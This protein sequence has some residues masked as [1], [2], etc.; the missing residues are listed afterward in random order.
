MQLKP[1]TVNW[2]VSW[3]I[4]EWPLHVWMRWRNKYPAQ[5]V[6]HPITNQMMTLHLHSRENLEVRWN[7]HAHFAGKSTLLCAQ[8]GRVLK[9]VKKRWH[10]QWKKK[11][12]FLWKKECLETI[13]MM[14]KWEIWWP[15]ITS[16]DSTTSC[17]NWAEMRWRSICN[18]FGTSSPGNTNIRATRSFHLMLVGV[19]FSCLFSLQLCDHQLA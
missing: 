16:P 5:L 13:L 7:L 9:K 8:F 3:S 4:R 12:S 1:S 18:P 10:S 17:G 11:T 15:A 19:Y 2:A 6:Q 14:T